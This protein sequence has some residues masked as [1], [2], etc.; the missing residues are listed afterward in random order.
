MS[1]LLYV[2]ERFPLTD[3]FVYRL[4][5]ITGQTKWLVATKNQNAQQES[6]EVRTF[7]CLIVC[8]GLDS[9]PKMPTIEG[10]SDEFEGMVI[11]SCGYDSPEVFR[12]M[13]LIRWFRETKD[14]AVRGVYIV[15]KPRDYQNVRLHEP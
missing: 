9:T 1:C 15:L 5:N 2:S 6:E 8:S 12:G 7:D 10:L 14:V 11:H 13:L 4:T 3:K